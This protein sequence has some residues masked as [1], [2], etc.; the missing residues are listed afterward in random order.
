MQD[1][2]QSEEYLPEAEEGQEGSQAGDEEECLETFMAA[3]QAKKRTAQHRLQRGFSGPKV[4]MKSSE[5]GATPKSDASHSTKELDAR[6]A[7]SRCA[8]CKQMGHWKGDPE[9]PRVQQGKT[10]KFEKPKA[11]I[12]SNKVHWF[13]VVSPVLEEAATI[14]SV[15]KCKGTRWGTMKEEVRIQFLTHRMVEYCKERLG[16]KS[17]IFFGSKYNGGYVQEYDTQIWRR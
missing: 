10:R 16:S 14:V 7:T 5:A 11:L 13:G 15:A 8:D 9:C 2:G 6:K 4:A 3:W 1:A 12:A 17:D